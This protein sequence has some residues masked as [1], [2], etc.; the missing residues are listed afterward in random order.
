MGNC[1]IPL[2]EIQPS[3]M[4]IFQS[5]AFALLLVIPRFVQGQTTRSF[6]DD[7]GVEHTTS[8]GKPTFLARARFALFFH[9]YGVGTEQIS[10]VCTYHDREEAR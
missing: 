10:A 3:T 5:L 4:N 1:I 8:E 7:H 2:E 6:V 9:H